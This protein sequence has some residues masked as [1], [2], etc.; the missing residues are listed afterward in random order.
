MPLTVVPIAQNSHRLDTF[1]LIPPSLWLWNWKFQQLINWLNSLL[2]ITRISIG[3][4]RTVE[5]WNVGM[6]CSLRTK[7]FKFRRTHLNFSASA[8]RRTLA[9]SSFSLRRISCSWTRI[10][11]A[12]STTW[13]CISSSFSRCFVLAACSSYAN[14]ASAFCQLNSI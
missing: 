11:W 5:F 4:L 6:K 13:I 7:R 14:S 9:S 3:S 1:Q 8:G 2:I 10:C 12:R